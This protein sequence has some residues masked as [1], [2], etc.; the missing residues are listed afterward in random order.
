MTSR[1]HRTTRW[2]YQQ[3]WKKLKQV[4][5]AGSTSPLTFSL[6]AIYVSGLILLDHRQTGERIASWLL[7]RVHDA[8]NRL[9]R[10]QPLSDRKS[11][12]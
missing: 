6:I 11:V 2:L 3:V 10:T 7:G 9:L 8:I 5:I 1:L 12:V 4:G